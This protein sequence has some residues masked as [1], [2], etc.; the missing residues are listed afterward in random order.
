M[1][2]WKEINYNP[3]TFQP[4]QPA[5]L[6]WWVHLGGVIGALLLAVSPVFWQQATIA[7]VY[8]LNACFVVTLLLLAI[9][10]SLK[11][12][13][14]GGIWLAFFAGLSLTHHRTM[15][16]LF[17]A[18]ALYLYLNQKPGFYKKPGFFKTIILS[19]LVGLAPLLLYLYLPWRGHIGSLDGTYENT[20]AGFWRQVSAG[21][22]GAFIF[23][24]PFDQER[25]VAFY[26]NLFKSQFYTVVPGFIGL[27]YLFW[28]GQRKFLLLTGTAFLTYVTFNLFYN[29]SD[30]EVFFIPPFLLWAAWSGVGVAFL[31][32]IAAG[33]KPT[34]DRRPATD[35][36]TFNVQRSTFG[37]CGNYSPSGYLRLYHLPTFPNQSAHPQDPEHLANP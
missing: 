22:Y 11:G 17:P 23:D 26:W 14:K 36:P 35:D 2:E 20:W 4:V 24:N 34:G 15:L 30:I 31:L 19:A 37:A 7:E 13:E 6:P 18:L 21:G 3:P 29:V 8:T 25:D 16:L 5:N 33:L 10:S 9:T 1:E 12:E 28:V 27:F 32:Q